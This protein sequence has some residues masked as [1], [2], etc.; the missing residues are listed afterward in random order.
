M[1]PE[2]INMYMMQTQQ[3]QQAVNSP[4]PFIRKAIES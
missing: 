2:Q 3:H 4:G 1:T